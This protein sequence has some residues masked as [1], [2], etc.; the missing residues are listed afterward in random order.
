M[1]DAILRHRRL[2]SVDAREKRLGAQAAAL[3][4]YAL[5]TQN[6]L[7]FVADDANNLFVAQRPD[8]LRIR[9][10]KKTTQ[11]S[12]VVRSPMRKF[13]VNKGR[14]QQLLAFTPRH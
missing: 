12:A 2:P 13:I 6:L 8:T 11:Q 7:Q 14:R 1:S 9:S 4:T 3:R 10:R 5:R